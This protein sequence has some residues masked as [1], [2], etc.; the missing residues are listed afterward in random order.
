MIRTEKFKLIYYAVGNRLQLFDM[1]NDLAEKYDLAGDPAHAKTLTDLT[2]I[3]VSRFYGA[4]LAWVKNGNLTGLPDKQFTF[5]PTQQN[6]GVLKNRELLIQRG[7][8]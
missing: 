1:E 2:N 5:K 8:R 4:D 6:V 7:I 3:L